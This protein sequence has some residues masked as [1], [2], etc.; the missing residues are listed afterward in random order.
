MT[1]EN[2]NGGPAGP[3][4]PGNLPVRDIIKGEICPP[5][6]QQPNLSIHIPFSSPCQPNVPHCQTAAG[7]GC[8]C[9]SP[10]NRFTGS[11]VCPMPPPGPLQAMFGQEK[12][13]FTASEAVCPRI[14]SGFKCPATGRECPPRLIKCTGS[15]GRCRMKEGGDAV[16]TAVADT[17][18]AGALGRRHAEVWNCRSSA[19]CRHLPGIQRVLLEIPPDGR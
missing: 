8:L 16:V 4:E 18:A 13:R 11:G 15:G 19:T 6:G 14:M 10:A 5:N 9:S 17:T 3:C 1:S 12:I 7:D 2:S